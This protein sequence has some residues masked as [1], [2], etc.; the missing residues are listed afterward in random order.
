VRKKEILVAFSAPETGALGNIWRITAKKTEFYLDP[1]GQKDV[2]HLSVHGPRDHAVNGHRFH[3]KVDR[4][5]ASAVEERGDFILHSIPRKGHIID[6]QELT[7]GAFRAARIRWLWDLQ[8]PRYHRAALSG[9]LPEISDNQ[10]GARL[11]R[12]LEP[13]EV[14]DLDLVVSYGQPYWPDGPGSL[15]DNARLV[16]RERVIL[17]VGSGSGILGYAVDCGR[18][19]SA[20][21]S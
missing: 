15:R 2:F 4:N 20:A 13:N 21:G 10:S 18:G 19:G 11:S 6:G 16:S 14:A 17:N 7:A 1:L 12:R 5:G 9:A 3:V 8:R